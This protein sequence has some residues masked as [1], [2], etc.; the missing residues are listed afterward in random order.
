MIPLPL[1]VQLGSVGS[2]VLNQNFFRLYCY[3]NI[4]YEISQ[5]YLNRA[6]IADKCK[7][8]IKQNSEKSFNYFLNIT[9]I[10]EESSNWEFICRVCEVS[11]KK[12]NCAFFVVVSSKYPLLIAKIDPPN[13]DI[14]E[15]SSN[16]NLIQTKRYSKRKF[17]YRNRRKSFKLFL[18]YQFG[19]CFLRLALYLNVHAFFSRYDAL[20]ILRMKIHAQNNFK[21]IFLDSFFQKNTQMM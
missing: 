21:N 11:W 20:N 17:L 13:Q 15:F 3:L 7:I 5:N 9:Y 6:L 2:K 10:F 8:R 16:K 14:Y 1:S 4:G 18:R 19:S 12:V